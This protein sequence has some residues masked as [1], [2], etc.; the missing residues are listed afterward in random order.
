MI[1]VFIMTGMF[2]WLKA[3]WDKLECLFDGGIQ[4]SVSDSIIALILIYILWQKIINWIEI[5][6]EVEQ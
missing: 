5:K 4:E 1:H 3:L 6:G 2:Y